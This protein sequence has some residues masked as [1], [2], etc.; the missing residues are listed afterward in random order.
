MPT[1]KYIDSVEVNIVDSFVSQPNKTGSGNGETRLYVGARSNREEFFGGFGFKIPVRIKKSEL[2]RFMNEMKDEYFNPVLNYRGKSDLPLLWEQRLKKVKQL[3]EE[4]IDFY[5]Y[6]TQLKSK[7]S[8]QRRIY[9]DS[10]DD[11]YHLLHELPLSGSARLNVVKYED[12]GRDFFEFKLLPDFDGYTEPPATFQ[13]SRW[14]H[15]ESKIQKNNA[16]THSIAETTVKR[17]IQARVGQLEFRKSLLN[18]NYSTCAFTGISE[19][20]LLIAGHIKPWR[21][22]SNDERLDVQNG[23]LFT[24]TFDRP[25]NNGY[26]SFRENKTL[27]VSPLLSRKSTTLLGLKEDMKVEI[28]IEGRSNARRR[29][30][31][32]YHRN[33]VYRD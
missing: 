10:E 6:D 8:D 15:S 17:I 23:L 31:L 24:P 7:T 20:G 27:M 13:I 4:N 21:V 14:N 2:I 29:N 22:S 26:I 33:F 18:S 16:P 28:P 12:S 11:A 9:I 25:F 19:A 3:P 1:R 5:V 32:E 30:Y